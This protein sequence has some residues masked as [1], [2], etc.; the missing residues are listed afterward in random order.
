[1]I[2]CVVGQLLG[3]ESSRADVADVADVAS[4]VHDAACESA[5]APAH[6]DGDADELLDVT[7]RRFRQLFSS[8]AKAG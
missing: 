3:R 5:V 6:A 7:L 2:A 8:F 1:M 4:M